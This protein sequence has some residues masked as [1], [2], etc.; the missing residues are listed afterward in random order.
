[1]KK[2]YKCKTNHEFREAPC[3]MCEEIPQEEK[4][5]PIDVDVVLNEELVQQNQE[6]KRELKKMDESQQYTKEMYESQI[7]LL[8]DIIKDAMGNNNY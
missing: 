7:E 3:A 4:I 6:L 1:M 2:I 8:K 5:V